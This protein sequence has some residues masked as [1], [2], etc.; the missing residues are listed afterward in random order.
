M[1][2]RLRGGVDA[3]SGGLV[4]TLIPSWLAPVSGPVGAALSV[5][6]A[7]IQRWIEDIVMGKFDAL[8]KRYS[9]LMLRSSALLTDITDRLWYAV[10]GE[11]PPASNP[12]VSSIAGEH[13]AALREVGIESVDQLAAADPDHL[14]NTVEVSSEVIDGWIEQAQQRGAKTDRPPIAET[15]NGK[16]VR[17]WVDRLT[18]RATVPV[19]AV[20]ARVGGAAEPRAHA[21]RARRA[22]AETWLREDGLPAVISPARHTTAVI[23]RSAAQGSAQVRLRFRRITVRAAERFGTTGGD[24]QSID[25]IGSAYHERL[26]EAE[27]TTVTQLATAD[28]ERLAGEIEVS[29][30]RVHRWTTQAVRDRSVVHQLRRRLLIQAVR[31]GSAVTDVRTA[32][33]VSLPDVLDTRAWAVVETTEE[34]DAGCLSAVGVGSVQQLAAANPVRLAG[35]VNRDVEVVAGWVD[36]AQTYEKYVIYAPPERFSR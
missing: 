14:E 35:A 29:P 7:E 1:R 36:A 33:S 32:N 12:S 13:A 17:R 21:L 10:T 34:I 26:S 3:A 6:V 5:V 18:D 16:R 25:G 9:T 2:S 22:T 30:K 23:R 15:Q 24:L 8:G 19:A 4:T 31:M 27:I 20:V 28:P 11:N